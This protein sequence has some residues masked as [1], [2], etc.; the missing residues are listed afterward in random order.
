MLLLPSPLATVGLCDDELDPI[1]GR[2]LGSPNKGAR[3]VEI[4]SNQTKPGCPMSG[5]YAQQYMC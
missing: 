1:G 3:N 5:F 4:S 2:G